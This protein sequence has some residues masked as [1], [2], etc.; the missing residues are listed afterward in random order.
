M[1][2]ALRI[3]ILPWR[4]SKPQTYVAVPQHGPHSLSTTLEAH[5]QQFWI[6]ISH[7]TTFGKFSRSRLLV[8][9][10][11]GPHQRSEK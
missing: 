2:L 8:Y 9:M 3:V 6:Y 10:Q 1:P 4:G 11:K 7:G 5:Q